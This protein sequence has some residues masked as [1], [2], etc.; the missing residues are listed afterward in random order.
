MATRNLRRHNA[1]HLSQ[2]SLVDASIHLSS[3][4]WSWLLTISKRIAAQ[5]KTKPEKHHLV[6]SDTLY[7]LGIQLMDR[8]LGM[9]PATSWRVQTATETGS[10]LRC[11]HSFP[12]GGARWRRSH[13]QTSCDL[14]TNGSLI[15]QP[16]T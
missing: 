7:E 5:A 9:A 3:E 12:C 10:S 1:R 2:S 8:A 13:R 11:S 15:Y 6:T 4:D 14:A 16:R